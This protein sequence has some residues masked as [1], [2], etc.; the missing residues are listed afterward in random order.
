MDP[1]QRLIGVAY[2][3]GFFAFMLYLTM[4]VVH[5]VY[6]L[7]ALLLSGY[8]PYLPDLIYIVFVSFLPLNLVY[9]SILSLLFCILKITNVRHTEK[10]V[11]VVGCV[12]SLAIVGIYRWYNLLDPLE[13]ELTVLLLVRLVPGTLITAYLMSKMRWD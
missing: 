3:F 8:I 11:A 4:A 1:F 13:Q 2:L 5:F 6:D 9:V 10:I 7:T 12:L